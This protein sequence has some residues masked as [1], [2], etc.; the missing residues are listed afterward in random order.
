MLGGTIRKAE[1]SLG[2]VAF[3][4]SELG[5]AIRLLE[6]LDAKV[7][8]IRFAPRTCTKITA[9]ITQIYT[10]ETT[11]SMSFTRNIT[12]KQIVRRVSSGNGIPGTPK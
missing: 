4:E 7:H 2:H 1:Q 12:A 5:L 11:L 8:S 10:P 3:D 9:Y 6:L